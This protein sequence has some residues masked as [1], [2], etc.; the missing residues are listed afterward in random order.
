MTEIFRKKITDFLQKT[1]RTPIPYKELYTKISPKK[2]ENVD[3]NAALK[4]LQDDGTVYENR[5]G[6]VLSQSMGMFVATV[7]RLNKTFGFITRT[8][9]S[10]D[11]FVPGRFFMAAMPNDIVLA[12]EIPS[13][14]GS[15]EGEIVKI[16]KENKSTF[17]GTIIELFGKTMI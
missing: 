6:F 15:P 8:D 10:V 7:K 16:I 5:T 3:F 4:E 2:D 17:S 11:Y 12:K 13:R 14:T 9:D 1:K